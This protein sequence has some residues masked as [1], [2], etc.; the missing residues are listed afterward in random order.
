MLFRSYVEF[1]LKPLEA[2][3]DVDEEALE[4]MGG[5]GNRTLRATYYVTEDA[6]WRLAKFLE[7]C[8]IEI[9]DGISFRE[10]INYVPNQ[11]V[12]AHVKHVPSQDGT[13]V[14]ANVADTAAVS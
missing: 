6:K 13:T 11:Q 4:E 1:T 8:G 10:Y 12:L 14:F 9:E 3:D 5:I 7:D 2:R